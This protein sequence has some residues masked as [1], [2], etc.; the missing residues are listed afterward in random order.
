MIGTID[1]ADGLPTGTFPAGYDF[2]WVRVD[3]SDNEMDIG[4]NSSAYTLVAADA[5]KTFKVQ[6]RFTDDAGYSEG[7]LTSN[8][9]PASTVQGDLRLVDDDGPTDTGKGRLEA[10]FRGQWGT[11]CD[12]RFT[13]AFDNPN[14]D[15]DPDDYDDA[16]DAK[17][18]NIAPQFACR[19]MGHATG[20]VVSRTSLG[21][22]VVPQSENQKIWLDDVRCAAGPGGFPDMAN[23]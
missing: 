8:E 17:V 21:M 10:F 13:R 4:A 11:V 9:Y 7:P 6:V 3:A 15:L 18:P 14:D 20:E 2:Q 22:S 5:G 16:D 19:L 12:D 23:H 1:D